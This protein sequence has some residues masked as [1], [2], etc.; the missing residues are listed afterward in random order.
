MTTLGELEKEVNSAKV[1]RTG[2][3][4]DYSPFIRIAL[5]LVIFWLR[6]TVK[7]ERFP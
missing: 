4:V 5:K 1:E 7:R 6:H 3:A 2:A